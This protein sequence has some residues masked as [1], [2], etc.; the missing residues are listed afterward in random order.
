MTDKVKTA[1]TDPLKLEE[2]MTSE[3]TQRFTSWTE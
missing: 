1:W 3:K 2:G